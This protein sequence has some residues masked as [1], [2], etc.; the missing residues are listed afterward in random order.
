MCLISILIY[1][2][3]VEHED[4]GIAGIDMQVVVHAAMF[5]ARGAD[6]I[7]EKAV[8]LLPGFRAGCQRC[9]KGNDHGLSSASG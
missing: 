9:D 8:K 7:D 2:V 1:P 3:L 5:G 6:L 4:A